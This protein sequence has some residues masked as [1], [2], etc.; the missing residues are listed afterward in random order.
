MNHV[1]ASREARIGGAG[2]GFDR[3][4]RA[5]PCGEGGVTAIGRRMEPLTVIGHQ[6][7]KTRLAQPHRFFQHRVEHR[8]EVAG[9]GIDD[10]Q[11]LGG[12]GLLLQ[13][14]ARLAQEARILDRDHRLVRE[15]ADQ[16]DVPLGERLDLLS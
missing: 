16:L 7:A 5:D 2:F 10:L 12:R 3:T 14:F 13:G 1:F 15:G 11:H 6:I 4:L 9:R 8:G